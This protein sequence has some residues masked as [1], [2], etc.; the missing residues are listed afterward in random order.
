MEK[1]PCFRLFLLDAFVVLNLNLS[2]FTLP[3]HCVWIL[4]IPSFSVSPRGYQPKALRPLN[5]GYDVGLCER[6]LASG[7]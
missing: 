3:V 7:P 4:E 5:P 1:T 6:I 2:Y